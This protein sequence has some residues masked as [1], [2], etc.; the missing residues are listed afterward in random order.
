M[1]WILK[2]FLD[3]ECSTLVDMPSLEAEKCLMNEKPWDVGLARPGKWKRIQCLEVIVWHSRLFRLK[4]SA[5]TLQGGRE[6]TFWGR[7]FYFVKFQTK[8]R[9]QTNSKKHHHKKDQLAKLWLISYSKI[10]QQEV[11]SNFRKL[12]SYLTMS[13]RICDLRRSTFL[14]SLKEFRN[15]FS[16]KIYQK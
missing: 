12:V 11:I 4:E 7:K 13:F 5:M 9:T 14:K 6:L 10:A 3:L 15:S 16:E 1:L 8:W 2:F